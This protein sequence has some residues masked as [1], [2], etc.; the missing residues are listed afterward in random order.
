M[1]ILVISDSHARHDMLD[2]LVEKAQRIDFP[3]VIMHLGDMISDAKYLRRCVSQPVIAVTGNC[4]WGKPYEEEFIEHVE[5]LDILLCHGHTYRV[6]Q[7]L[8]PLTLRAREVGAQI[9]LFGHTHT[10]FQAYE[11]GILLL[12]PGAFMNEQCAILTV[13]GAHAEAELL[14]VEDLC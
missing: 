14:R 1:R 12:N 4:D 8:L 3:D 7:T 2:L 11:Q 13:K 6:K 9:A 5:G 10:P